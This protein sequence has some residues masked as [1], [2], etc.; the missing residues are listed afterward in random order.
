MEMP[1]ELRTTTEAAWREVDLT[2]GLLVADE[3]NV[4]MIFVLMTAGG[5][6]HGLKIHISPCH[7]Q[8]INTSC[9]AGEMQSIVL[10]TALLIRTVYAAST[11][12]GT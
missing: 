10:C 9:W 5:P 8:F 4:S 1:P 11:S 2:R 6:E 3:N 12:N 7:V